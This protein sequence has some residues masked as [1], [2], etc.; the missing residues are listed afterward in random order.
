MNRLIPAMPTFP[1]SSMRWEQGE[2]F[3]QLEKSPILFTHH[4]SAAGVLVHPDLWNRLIELLEE[5]DDAVVA[6]GRLLE[7][8][9]FVSLEQAEAELRRIRVSVSQ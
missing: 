5:R 8:D 3:K 2:I 6:R 9:A 1:A 7:D 4:G